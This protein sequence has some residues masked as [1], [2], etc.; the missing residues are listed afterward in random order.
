MAKTPPKR[1]QG[2]P[3]QPNMSEIAARKYENGLT[4][5]YL[6]GLQLP[7]DNILTGRLG[8]D[9][10]Q[11]REILRDDQVKA[12]FQQRQ[13]A[14]V[15]KE[16]EVE[17]GGSGAADK[18]VADMLREN[19]DAIEWDRIC[20]RMLY[21]I[22]FGYA[23]GE[24]MYKRDGRHVVLDDVRVRRRERFKF[25][26][27]GQLR[28]CDNPANADGQPLPDR[29]F[30]LVRSGGDHDDYLYGLGLAHELYWPTFFKRNAVR[31][32]LVFLDKFG[33]PTATAKVPQGADDNLR[34][35][36]LEALQALQTDS[37]VTLPAGFEVELLEASRS[38]TVDYDRFYS[39]MDAAISKTVLSQTMTTD[40]GSSRAQGQVHMDVREEVVK[41]DADLLHMSFTR[42]VVTW[43]RDWNYP[44]AALPRVWRRVEAEPDLKALAERDQILDGIGYHPT[45]KYITETYG[46]EV[47]EREDPPPALVG[48]GRVLP[49]TGRVIDDDDDEQPALGF[50]ELRALGGGLQAEDQRAM[51]MAANVLAAQYQE[52]LGDRIEQLIQQLQRDG[53]LSVFRESLQV[54][55]AEQPPQT[56]VDALSRQR[57]T[58]ALLGRLRAQR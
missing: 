45:L 7:E 12:T 29:K 11:Y 18:A 31:F 42:Q 13:L 10:N 53:D 49:G 25:N 48:A 46:V 50:N 54:L 8:L 20:S 28:L 16:W 24:C 22:F 51:A 6:Q 41:A 17:A 2:R 14:L 33:M 37:A 55:M 52:A 5:Q 36:V 21:A 27:D 47:T 26:H 15:S 1:S 34:R 39:R 9:W 44:G 38:G 19:L 23:V 43:L 58:A 4:R 30:W 56:L 57:F 40:D 3:P 32:W 35:Q